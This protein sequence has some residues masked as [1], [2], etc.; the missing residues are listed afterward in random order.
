MPPAPCPR[1]AVAR[2]ALAAAAALLAAGCATTHPAIDEGD[3]LMAEGRVDEAV[4]RIEQGLREAPGDPRLRAALWRQRDLAIAHLVAQAE[5][6]RMAGR[7]AAARALLERAQRLDAS[8]PRVRDTLATLDADQRVAELLAL[9]H[10]RHAAGDTDAALARLRE[11]LALAPRHVQA[12]RLAEQLRAQPQR[13]PTPTAAMAAALATPVTLEFRD[14]PLTAVF[15]VL[16]RTAGVNFVFDRDVRPDIRVTIFVRQTPVDEVVRLITRTN[17]LE[18]VALNANT[19]LIHPD[20]PAKAREYQELV[21][22][23]FFLANAEA[24]QVQGMVRALAG[25]TSMF[26]DERLNALV[27]KDSP[28]AV[29]LAERLIDSIDVAEPEVVLEVE[30]LEVNRTRLLELGLRFP[31]QIG[32]GRLQG[33]RATTIISPGLPQV[34]TPIPG[35]QLAP[36]FVDINALGNLTGFIANPALTLNLRREAGDGNTLA[37]PRI[38]VR[39]REKARIHIGD[40]LPVFTTTAQANV[41]VTASVSF[42]D[43]GLKLDV[44]PLVHLGDE[45]SMKVQ[46]EVSSVVREISGPAGAL[47]F[48]IGT[49]S[50]STA[51]R[52]RDGETQVLAGLIS[53]EERNSANRLPGLGD[54][55]I[56]G[57]LFG[58]TRDSNL[59]T[60]IVLLITP[61]VVR[62]VQPPDFA[63]LEHP[64][65][66]AADVGIA[67]LR[68]S[69]TAPGALAITSGTGRPGARPAAAPPPAPEAPAEPTPAVEPPAPAAAAPAA[70]ATPAA[71][72][73]PAAAPPA[74][75]PGAVRLVP[76]APLPATPL[77]GQ[78]AP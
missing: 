30:V 40:R 37:N 58:S 21:T 69:P 16:A 9:A 17:G 8:H 38:R 52:L 65:G 45:V 13:G 25:T 43:V 53:S 47:A 75:A 18:R 31:D 77:P 49:R 28:E 57:R 55:P 48:Q 2:L 22:R 7:V 23:T 14:A 73:A 3:A 29:R 20:T 71:E 67:P 41:G 63:R 5:A 54:L 44:E 10:E 34:T 61:R 32:L 59:R 1:R 66:T 51:L 74:P 39:N 15:E 24:R 6:E 68:L 76:L 11:A 12:R 78:R 19:L 27:V 70:P 26:V 72:A 46:L 33:E 35:G 4:A 64:A 56:V 42:L 50:A 36:G 62:S 60:E